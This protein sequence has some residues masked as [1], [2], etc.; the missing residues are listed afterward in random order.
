MQIFRSDRWA[1][2]ILLVILLTIGALA[3]WQVVSYT[4]DQIHPDQYQTVAIMIFGITAGFMLIAGAFGLWTIDFM[5][6]T[7]TKRRVG[8]IVD[9][10]D[11]LSDGIMVLDS[12]GNIVGSNSAVRQLLNIASISSKQFKDFVPS[13]SEEDFNQLTK[14]HEPYEVTHEVIS[15]GIMRTLRF[16]SQPS[17]ELT[18]IVVSDVTVLEARRA[19]SRHMAKLQLIAQLARGVAHDFNGIL[20]TISGHAAVLSKASEISPDIKSAIKIIASDAEKGITL[21]RHLIEFAQPRYGASS[22]DNIAQHIIIAS[23]TIRTT[24]SSLW[25]VE[26]EIT[27]DLPEVG[28]NGIQ[29]EQVLFNLGLLITDFAPK[30]NVIKIFAGHPAKNTIFDVSQ[31]FACSIVISSTRDPAQIMQGQMVNELLEGESGVILPIVRSIIEDND[32]KLE[33][34]KLPDDSLTFRISLPRAHKIEQVEVD[35]DISN[36]LSEYLSG[37]SVLAMVS[38]SKYIKL[39]KMLKS[40][41]LHITHTDNPVS[42][43]AKIET[44]QDYDVIIA[45]K[46]LIGTELSATLRVMLKLSPHSAL[47]VFT[48]SPNLQ[49]DPLLKENTVL[50]QYD[51]TIYKLIETLVEARRLAANR[52]TKTSSN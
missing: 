24:V 18:L 48:D 41:K 6:Q 33:T 39:E 20:T 12:N 35:F 49:L 11:F 10:M 46:E 28:I 21:A 52:K 51:T 2:A 13:L 25:Q 23:D 42:T 44:E 37:W 5:V 19:H 38:D 7:E 17:R 27:P 29:I 14:S 45:D 34:I 36:N 1:Y 47:V 43:M 9:A 16:R 22:T 30:S 4:M 40:L 50:L 8:H 32:G 26:Y 15:D 3:V 31:K